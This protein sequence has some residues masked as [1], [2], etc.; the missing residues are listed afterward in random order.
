MARKEGLGPYPYPTLST[1][2]PPQID[3]RATRLIDDAVEWGCFDC[4]HSSDSRHRINSG[5]YGS[6]VQGSVYIQE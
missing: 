1:D 5:E 6:I 2:Y 4:T 3:Y